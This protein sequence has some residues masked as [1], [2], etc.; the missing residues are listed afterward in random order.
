MQ[1]L[2]KK[3]LL[4]VIIYRIVQNI[5]INNCVNYIARGYNSI[6]NNCLWCIDTSCINCNAN[7]MICTQCINNYGLVGAHCNQCAD[8]NCIKCD[9]NINICSVCING[10]GLDINGLCIVSTPFCPLIC[11]SCLASNS[12]ICTSCLGNRLLVNGNCL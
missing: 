2:G 11:A 10:Y 5:V 8:V 3:Q 7:Y 12:S 4:I 1:T 6:Y 9:T